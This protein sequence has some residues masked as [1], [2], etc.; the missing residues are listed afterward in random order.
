ME[1]LQVERDGGIVTV[2]L[3]KPQK[4]NAVDPTMW[5]EMARIWDDIARNPRRDRAVVVTGAGGDFCSGADLWLPP[6]EEPPHQL[7]AMR[8]VSAAIQ[9]LHDLPQPTIA[10]VPGVAA[11]AGCSLALACDLIVAGD[12]ARFAEIF[13]KRGLA[14]DGGSSWLLPRLVGLHRAKELAF[15]GDIV[16]AADAEAMGL[17]NRVVPDAELDEFVSG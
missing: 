9:G 14:L 2:T 5:V 10:K 12:R 11:G 17:V 13:P 4:K 7:T 8:A 3:N 1:T 6:G 16:S 15:F